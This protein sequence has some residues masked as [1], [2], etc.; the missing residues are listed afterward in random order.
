VTGGGGYHW[1]FAFP[2]GVEWLPSKTL[3]PGVELKADGV[4][5][6]LPPSNHESGG[7]YSILVDAPLVPLPTWVLER[8][9][10]PELTVHEGR[11]ESRATLPTESRFELPECIYEGTRNR[12]LYRYGCSLRAHGWNHTMILDK[13]RHTNKKRCVPPLD[14]AEISKVAQSAE[15]HTLGSASMVAPEVLETL[16]LLQEKAQRR[17]KKGIGAHSRWAVYRALIDCAREHGWMYQGRD[18]AVRISVRQLALDSGVSK[19]TVRSALEALDEAL[20]V[21]RASRGDGLHPGVLVLRVPRRAHPLPTRTTPPVPP[22]G[23][24]VY[25]SLPLYRAR[26]GYSMSKLDAAVLEQIVECPGSRREETAARLGPGRTPESLKRQL[27]K[28]RE[29]VGLVENRGMR[30]RYWPVDNW[31]HLLDRERTLSGE[32]LA[33]NLDRQRYEREREA[34]RRHLAEREEK[35]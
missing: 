6:L 22:T 14:D 13:L 33:E 32:K 17:T 8:V 31:Q 35:M 34:Y 9:L 10:K 4:G 11:S 29:E 25:P 27:K 23:K 1:V 26:H 2:E 12:T 3:V 5:V 16:A 28:L 24:A 18:V 15:C 30:G 7:E 20:L 21:Y 19:P